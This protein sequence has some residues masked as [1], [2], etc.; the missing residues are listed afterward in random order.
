LNEG[1][2]LASGAA[3]A[4]NVQFGDIDGYV[5]YFPI[6]KDPIMLTDKIEMA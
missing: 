5:C 4:S 6:F 2:P 3:P 1:K